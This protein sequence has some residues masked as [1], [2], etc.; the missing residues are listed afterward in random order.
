[1]DRFTKIRNT[2]DDVLLA[3]ITNHKGL[4]QKA[5]DELTEVVRE[6]CGLD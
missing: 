5:N 3:N 2:I 6:I 4:R 1:M